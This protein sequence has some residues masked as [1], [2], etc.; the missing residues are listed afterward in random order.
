MNL[1]NLRWRL[2]TAWH[3]LTKE[4]AV[5]AFRELRPGKPDRVTFGFIGPWNLYEA[6]QLGENLHE[7]MQDDVFDEEG[8]NSAVSELVSNP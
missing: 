3:M 7:M 5:F 6:R 1:H 2:R 8:A 4:S